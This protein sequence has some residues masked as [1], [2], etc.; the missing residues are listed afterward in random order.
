VAAGTSVPGIVISKIQ[1]AGQPAV[2]TVSGTTKTITLAVREN[3]KLALQ[4]RLSARNR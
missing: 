3:T 4:P 2:K 1:A